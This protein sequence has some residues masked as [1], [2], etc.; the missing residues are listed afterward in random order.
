ML[1]ILSVL[2]LAAIFAVALVHRWTVIEFAL[3]VVYDAVL[4]TLIA[5]LQRPLRTL[6]AVA[7][8]IDEPTSSASNG[9]PWFMLAMFLILSMDAGIALGLQAITT[10][11]PRSDTLELATAWSRPAQ[12]MIWA[13]ALRAMFWL[14]AMVQAKRGSLLRSLVAAGIATLMLMTMTMAIAS[15]LFDDLAAS[16]ALA[17]IVL[18]FWL[19]A[20]A[21]ASRNS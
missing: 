15:M 1:R 6:S 21:I 9:V 10:L 18:A 11:P 5:L 14:I 12:G 20:S 2:S 17:L 7:D 8:V 4:V 3:I 13:F 16:Q 19:P